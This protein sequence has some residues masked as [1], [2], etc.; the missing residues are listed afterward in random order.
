MKTFE[1]MGFDPDKNIWH[2]IIL[3]TFCFGI[4]LPA[5][6]IV[7]YLLTLLPIK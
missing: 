2:R 5:P 3:I 6:F 4:L 1:E 7:L